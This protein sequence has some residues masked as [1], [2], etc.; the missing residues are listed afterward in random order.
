MYGGNILSLS[1]FKELERFYLRPSAWNGGRKL[2][3]Y[4]EKGGKKK[5]GRRVWK[6][7]CLLCTLVS[8]LCSFPPVLSRKSTLFGRR[9]DILPFLTDFFLLYLYEEFDFVLDTVL[10]KSNKLITLTIIILC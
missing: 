1:M 5:E 8:V 7:R 6:L 3:K 2:R 10:I 9:G 4:L